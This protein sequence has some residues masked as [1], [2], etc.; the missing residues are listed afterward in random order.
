MHTVTC[1]N[2]STHASD[3]QFQY[4]RESYMA[5]LNHMN[6]LARIKVELAPDY[7]EK[8]SLQVELDLDNRALYLTERWTKFQLPSRGI[9]THMGPIDITE[10]VNEK[11]QSGFDEKR[12]SANI[13]VASTY[14]SDENDPLK[15]VVPDDND[16]FIDPRLKNYPIPQVAKTV[17]LHND[18]K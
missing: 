5:N 15:V 16:E 10:A 18:D 8:S 17:D 14:S 6:M 11:S 9:F 13:E 7:W 3:L 12:N 4:T 1:S 2:R